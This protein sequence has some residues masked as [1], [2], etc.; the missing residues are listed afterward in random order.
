MTQ[1]YTTLK[2]LDRLKK[3]CDI[4]RRSSGETIC[5]GLV[6]NENETIYAHVVGVLLPPMARRWFRKTGKGYG[7]LSMQAPEHCNKVSKTLYKTR[8]NGKWNMENY[9]SYAMLLHFNRAR[10]L[11]TAITVI[12][13]QKKLEKLKKENNDESRCLFIKKNE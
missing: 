8:T 1:L 4:F 12:R 11:E 9:D 3:L 2:S 7:Y 10:Y 13:G 6:S 5:K